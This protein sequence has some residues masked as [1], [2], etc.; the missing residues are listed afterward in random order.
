MRIGD[1][2]QLHMGVPGLDGPT[3]TIIEEHYPTD[4]PMIVYGGGYPLWLVRFDNGGIDLGGVIVKQ[5]I[6]SERYLVPFPNSSKEGDCN[7]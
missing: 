7:G 4:Q 2:V 5:D 1:K 3:G 6:I